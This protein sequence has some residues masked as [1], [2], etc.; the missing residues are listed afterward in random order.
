MKSC[1]EILRFLKRNIRNYNPSSLQYPSIPPEYLRKALP[2][3]RIIGSPGLQRRHDGKGR[4]NVVLTGD[5]TGDGAH[6][7]QSGERVSKELV[8]KVF[9]RVHCA[10]QVQQAASGHSGARYLE[11]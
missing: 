4:Q 7:A 6:G 11:G 8:R 10:A 9:Q 2:K 1:Y 3:G 5:Q